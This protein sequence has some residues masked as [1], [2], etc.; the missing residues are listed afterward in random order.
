MTLPT[1]GNAVTNAV[2]TR[3]AFWENA[4]QT[5]ENT[6]TRIATGNRLTLQWIQPTAGN[7]AK[8]VM[9]AK[10]AKEENVKRA[11]D[12]RIATGNRL[13]LQMIL[14]TAGNAVSPALQA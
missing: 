7:A 4:K 2:S 13:T 1:A 5:I 12:T 6:G 9:S 10:C 11:S 14:Q 3:L 8:N